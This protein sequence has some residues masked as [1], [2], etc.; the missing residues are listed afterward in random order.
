VNK[1]TPFL[2][3]RLHAD[4]HPVYNP[5]STYSWNEAHRTLKVW[6]AFLSA[7]VS[8]RI[9]PPPAVIGRV[10][11]PEPKG[12]EAVWLHAEILHLADIAAW[13]G[14]LGLSMA[15]RL[16]WDGLC[17]HRS[18]RVSCPSPDGPMARKGLRSPQGAEKPKSASDT[19]LPTRRE[20]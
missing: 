20:R 1:L 16:A 12:R 7:L 14:F 18:T 19:P 10:S 11:N 2:S 6:R 13:G 15:V 8:Y 4:I 17:Y 3:E 5:N 9:L